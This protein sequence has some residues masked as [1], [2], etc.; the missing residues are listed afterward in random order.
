MHQLLSDGVKLHEVRAEA[1]DRAVYMRKPIGRKRLG[2]HA[3]L[4]LIDH[5]QAFIGSCNLDPRSFR[6]N[7]EVGLVIESPELNH[8]LT[9]LLALDFHSDNAWTVRLSPKGELVW[10]D[11]SGMQH[12][13]PA[14][15]QLQQLEDWFLGML[16]IDAEM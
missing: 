14:D 1:R 6:I 8:R 4:L 13:E 16:S 11:E 10:I 9:E 15:S 12:S 3:K 2:L 5:H 7:T